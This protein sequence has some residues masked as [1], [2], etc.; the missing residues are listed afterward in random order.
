M[1]FI[2]KELHKIRVEQ[3]LSRKEVAELMQVCATNL[4][5]WE[6]GLNNPNLTNL[7]S[8]VEAL[9]YELELMKR[10]KPNV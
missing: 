4:K 1:S 2:V 10:E 8:W 5:N 9:G 3:G 6:L 7:E